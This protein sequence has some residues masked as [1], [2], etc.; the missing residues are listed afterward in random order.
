L[1]VFFIA[2][3]HSSSHA[4]KQAGEIG[5]LTNGV[6]ELTT[7]TLCLAGRLPVILVGGTGILVTAGYAFNEIFLYWFPNFGFAFILLGIIVAGNCIGEKWAFYC[8]VIA[9][10]CCLIGLV[11]ILI[12]WGFFLTPPELVHGQEE[13]TFSLADGMNIFLLFLGC[14]L[15]LH[16]NEQRDARWLSGLFVMVFILFAFWIFFSRQYVAP[17]VLFESTIPHIKAAKSALGQTGRLLIGV[18][19]ISGAF[20]MING[21]FIY[22]GITLERMNQSKLIAVGNNTALVRRLL[23]TFL[24][25][26]IGILMMTGLAGSE[27]LEIYYRGSLLL[28]LFLIGMHSFSV[29]RSLRFVSPGKSKL[30][31][32]LSAIFIGGLV[33]LILGDEN[34][35]L[36]SIFMFL[37]MISS[38]VFSTLWLKIARRVS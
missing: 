1:A 8:Q 33:F 34:S 4:A 32:C 11:A 18:V 29:S 38:G 16:R 28:W 7:M 13:F 9:S 35:K 3:T 2:V 6:G 5:V 26:A 14:D 10:L 17:Q 22:S 19:I 20:A 21:L 37:I 25:V 30:S 24:A 36:L 23:F 12:I 31:L 15:A 27:K